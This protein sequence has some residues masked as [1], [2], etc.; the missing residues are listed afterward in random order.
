MSA[1]VGDLDPRVERTRQ[2]VLDAVGE[3]LTREGY[4]SVTVEGIAR[5]TGVARSTIYRHWPSLNGLLFE[6]YRNMATVVPE[7]DTGSLAGDVV[8]FLSRLTEHLRHDDWGRAL[9]TMID[10]SLRDEELFR[11]QRA[12]SFERR[13]RIRS[14]LQRWVDRGALD[15][16]TDLGLL[17]DQLVGPIFYRHLVSHQPIGPAYVAKLVEQVLTPRDR[18]SC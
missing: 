6:A 18:S 14:V 3:L 7:P 13:A 1:A 11:H 15:A 17:V 10:A 16:D 2:V 12:L 5:R 4:T 8:E 9:P